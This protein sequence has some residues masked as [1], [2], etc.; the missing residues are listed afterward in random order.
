M[1]AEERLDQQLASLPP[2]E[3]DPRVEARVR[4]RSLAIFQ[5][6]AR[7]PSWLR[8]VDALWDGAEPALVSAS[9]LWILAWAVAVVTAV[10][11]V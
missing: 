7:T 5:R 8:T 3:L 10:G 4:R 1:N 2:P 9:T 11:R 6:V